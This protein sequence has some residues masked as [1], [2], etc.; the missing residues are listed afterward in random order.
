MAS[1]IRVRTVF[2]GVPGTPWY[3]NIYF[4]DDGVNGQIGIDAV[5]TFWEALAGSMSPSV[6]WQVEGQVVVLDSVTGQ[7]TG[8]F[9]GTGDTGSGTGTGDMLPSANQVLVTLNTGVWQAGRQIRGR[10]FC[11]GWTESANDGEGQVYSGLVTAVLAAVT[12]MSEDPGNL[13]QLVWSRTGN[14]VYPVSSWS[15]SNKFALLKSR[16]D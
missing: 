11:P 15:V 8:V 5:Q 2:S 10:L 12:A 1:F 4:D 6:D 14:V 9:S 7:P 3:S 16:R 13:T